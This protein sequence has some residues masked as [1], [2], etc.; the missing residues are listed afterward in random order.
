M[1][2][3]ISKLHRARGYEPPQRTMRRRLAVLAKA[4]VNAKNAAKTGKKEKQMET[5]TSF[6]CCR[7]KVEKVKVNHAQLEAELL[8]YK[9]SV[10]C[11]LASVQIKKYVF[12]CMANMI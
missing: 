3:I 5:W 2:K 1:H 9:P 8:F 6:R 7:H 11:T 10:S 12:E 4:R